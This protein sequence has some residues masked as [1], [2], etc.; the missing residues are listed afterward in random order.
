MKRCGLAPARL[1]DLAVLDH[2]DLAR[3]A[4]VLRCLADQAASLFVRRLRAGWRGRKGQSSKQQEGLDL[5]LRLSA[6]EDIPA[7]R[8]VQ[9]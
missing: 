2:C 5:P 1:V 7:G 3:N 8:A 6:R 9:P 4:L